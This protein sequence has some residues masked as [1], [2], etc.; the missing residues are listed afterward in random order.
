MV[1]EVLL[2]TDVADLGAEGDIVNVADGYARN[3]L[4]P[5]KLGATVTEATRR[6]L[7]DVRRKREAEHEAELDTAVEEAEKL[8]NV[9]CTI[10]VKVGEDGK[11]YGS[12]TDANIAEA[13]K[14]QEIEI[15]RHSLL[16]DQPIKELGVFDVKVKFHSE[17][18]ATVK[19]WVVE[20]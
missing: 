4:F 2:M 15:D 6:Q 12:V 17:V 18:E 16:L 19:V 3:Y 8:E 7:E 1:T 14:S 10:S 20:E 9:S 5:Q 11:M 13:L